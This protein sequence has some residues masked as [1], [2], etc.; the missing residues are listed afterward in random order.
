MTEPTAADVR[1]A[2]AEWEIHLDGDGW[3][4]ARL[5]TSEDWPQPKVTA[6]TLAGLAGEI[7]ELIAGMG[8]AS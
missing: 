3:W 8:S 5:A 7:N 6:R 1:A 4:H 2:F